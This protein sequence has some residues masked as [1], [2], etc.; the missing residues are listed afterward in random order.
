MNPS[1]RLADGIDNNKS[2]DTN[3]YPPNQ[4]VFYLN[5]YSVQQGG[6]NKKFAPPAATDEEVK[7]WIE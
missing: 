4:R 6:V 3:E 1:V 5:K 7:E 2:T